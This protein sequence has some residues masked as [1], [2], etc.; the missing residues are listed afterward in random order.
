MTRNQYGYPIIPQASQD[1]LEPMALHGAELTP[2]QEAEAEFE[3]SA[4]AA[5]FLEGEEL[6]TAI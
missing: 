6:Y 3:A 1:D 4:E 2:E 5:L